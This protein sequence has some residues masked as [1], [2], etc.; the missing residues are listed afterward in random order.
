MAVWVGRGENDEGQSVG[1]DADRGLAPPG[2]GGGLLLRIDVV[3]ADRGA[4]LQAGDGT[5]IDA[6]SDAPSFIEAD[7][8]EAVVRAR[9]VE[10]A[11]RRTKHPAG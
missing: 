4:S 6:T 3:V 8:S 11:R 9:C 10:A 1:Q 5:D 2:D 7:P